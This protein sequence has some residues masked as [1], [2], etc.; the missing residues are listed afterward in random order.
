MWQN[1]VKKILIL[2]LE[3]QKPIVKLGH[4]QDAVGICQISLSNQAIRTQSGNYVD[5][6]VKEFIF[7]LTKFS[8]DE[9]VNRSMDWI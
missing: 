9:K 7:N 2:P 4:F 1:F 5:T 8:R 6:A 3:S